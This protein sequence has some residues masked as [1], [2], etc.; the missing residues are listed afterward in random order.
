MKKIATQ[1]YISFIIKILRLIRFLLLACSLAIILRSE[2]STF[3]KGD[4][5]T[6]LQCN[7]CCFTDPS[8]KFIIS[9][10]ATGSR[11]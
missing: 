6:K 5:L 4:V 1:I 7:T 11:I 3:S 9:S 2:I 8:A 10:K